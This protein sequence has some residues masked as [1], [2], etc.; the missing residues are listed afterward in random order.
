MFVCVL[1][2]TYLCT[3]MNTYTYIFSM[4]WVDLMSVRKHLTPYTD[5]FF[6]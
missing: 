2:G 5:V 1:T 6:S 3:P 4:H